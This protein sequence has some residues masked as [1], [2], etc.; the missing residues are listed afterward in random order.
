MRFLVAYDGTDGAVA[1]L[2]AAAKLARASAAEVTVLHVLNPLIDA[3]DI[4]APTTREALAKVADASRTALTARLEALDLVAD[5]RIEQLTH[6]EDD[7]EHVVHVAQDI[8]ADIVVIGSRRSSGLAGAL[9]G[10][11]SGAVVRHAP[12]PVL[13]VRP[14]EG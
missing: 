13:V 1:A 11:V 10:S 12:C 7:W 4:V 2:A 3:A 6:G 14:G 5:V 8:E 9:L